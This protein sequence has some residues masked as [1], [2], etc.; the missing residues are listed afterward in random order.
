MARECRIAALF[1]F[2][3]LFGCG[4]G[5]GQGQRELPT[6]TATAAADA[7]TTAVPIASLS[8]LNSDGRRTS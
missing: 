4:E 8:D 5:A 7:T 2:L 6:P 1:G 3:T